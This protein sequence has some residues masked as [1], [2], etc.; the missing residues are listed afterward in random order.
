ME[1]HFYH[2]KWENALDFLGVLSVL[3]LVVFLGVIFYKYF[4]TNA[5]RETYCEQKCF[6][7][8]SYLVCGDSGV[9]QM[10]EGDGD[11]LYLLRCNI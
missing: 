9:V 1:H 3:L 5:K 2:N 6:S 4:Y 8:Y 10:L 11:N 7:G